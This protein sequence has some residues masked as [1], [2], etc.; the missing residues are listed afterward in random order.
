[1]TPSARLQA[2]IEVLGGLQK[3]FQ[4]ADRFLRDWFR[5]RRYAGSKDR[6]AVGEKVFAVLRK[7]GWLAWRMQSE[8]PRALVIATLIDDGMDL[9]QIEALFPGEGYGPSVL[10]DAER[11]E[12]VRSGIGDAPLHAQG[13]FPPFLEDEL[14][15]AFGDDLLHQMLAL[16]TRATIDLRVN[17]LKA[18]RDEVLA[19]LQADGFAAHLMPHSPHGIRI[20]SGEGS[21]SLGRTALFESGAFEFQDEAA[22]IAAILCAARPGERIMDL[23]AGAGGKSLALAALMRNEGEILACDIDGARLNQLELRA[24][25]AGAT[26][27]RA[28]VIQREPPMGPFDAVF[29]DAPCS[30][31]GTWRRQPELRWRLSPQRLTDLMKVQDALLDTAA[32]RVKPGGRIVYATCSILPCENEDRVASFLDRHHG[33]SVHPAGAVWQAAGLAQTPGLDRFFHGSPRITGTDGFFAAI[34]VREDHPAG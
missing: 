18:R 6:A 32:A 27:V 1:M 15:R 14:T 4:P 30:G 19:A 24:V 23:A 16:Q 13:E 21:A 2:A 12:I 8:E 17:S 3:T 11:G 9:A 34:I 33:F 20:P 22:Q 7:R 29:V 28:H 26:I 5:T 25:R 10:T 31:S